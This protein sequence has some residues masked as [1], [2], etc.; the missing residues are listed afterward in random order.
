MSATLTPDD[1]QTRNLIQKFTGYRRHVAE[2]IVPNLTTQ[3]RAAIRAAASN[4]TTAEDTILDVLATAEARGFAGVCHVRER[5]HNPN[6][7]P[8][9]LS[10][11]D[12]QSRNAIEKHAGKNRAEALAIVQALTPQERQSVRTA[13]NNA[14]TVRNLAAA[15]SARVPAANAR[16]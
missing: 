4:P 1:L 3:E 8:D 10:A 9:A 11:A 12:M 6:V 7:A 15:G 2:A 16:P 13:R 5:G 14:G